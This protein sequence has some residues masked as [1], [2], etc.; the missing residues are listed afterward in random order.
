MATQATPLLLL[1]LLLAAGAAAKNILIPADARS[2]PKRRLMPSGI[3]T[4]MRRSRR[5]SRFLSTNSRP[6]VRVGFLVTWQDLVTDAL[7]LQGFNDNDCGPRA[8]ALR[9]H[10]RIF[11]GCHRQGQPHSG[12]HILNTALGVYLLYFYLAYE[13]N[14]DSLGEYELYGLGKRKFIS[15][16]SN[17]NR[18]RIT[19]DGSNAGDVTHYV[20]HASPIEKY[21][22][23]HATMDVYGHK[24]NPGQ[25]SSTG[26]WVSH[27]GDGAESSLNSVDAGWHISPDLYGD[28]Y[29]HFFTYWTRDGY[30]KTGCFNMKCRG[31]VRADSATITPGQIIHRGS[32][33][34]GGIQTITVRVLKEK[35]SG[36]WWVY[37]GFNSVPTAVGYYPRSLF[38]YMGTHANQLEFGGFVTTKRALLTPPMGSGTN[39]KAAGRGR[40]ASFSDLRFIDQDERS[41]PIM[42]DFSVV[43]SNEKC[44]SITPIDHAKCFYGGPGGCVG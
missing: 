9:A 25:L 44:Y 13:E 39:P 3:G 8:L 7:D 36:D 1:P 18:T 30:H 11:F 2:Q 19:R 4:N 38:A 26:L 6:A 5:L 35:K 42:T 43:V 12:G 28:S 34:G 10:A 41:R 17:T 21:Y 23:L 20:A 33:V 14:D 40:S 31:F 32:G 37:C 16:K 29:P 22:G 27:T 24:L 15:L